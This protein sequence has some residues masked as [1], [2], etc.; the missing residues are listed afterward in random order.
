MMC[1]SE[2]KVFS[3]DIIQTPRQKQGQSHASNDSVFEILD[4]TRVEV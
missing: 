1:V 4:F 2:C 3:G